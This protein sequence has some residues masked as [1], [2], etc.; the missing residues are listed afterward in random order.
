MVTAIRKANE[1][2]S[3]KM[4]DTDVKNV[5]GLVKH[6]PREWHD[7]TQD[8]VDYAYPLILGEPV[9]KYERGIPDY[10]DVSHLYLITKVENKL[11]NN[12]IKVQKHSYISEY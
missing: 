7:V 12:F 5:A 4:G 1:P 8:F 11:H 3:V 2:Y 10:L 9:V 6:V